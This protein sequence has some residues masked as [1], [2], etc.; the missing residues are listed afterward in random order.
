VLILCENVGYSVPTKGQGPS[1]I[2]TNICYSAQVFQGVQLPDYD[3]I[4][5]HSAGAH[6]HGEREDNDKGLGD[7]A[8]CGSNSIDEYLFVDFETGNGED[9][10]D[11][12]DGDTK[13]NICQLS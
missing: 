12:E 8:D 10:D 5:R 13:E 9:D 2:R 11:K 3:V 6:A 1:L 4:C 7:N